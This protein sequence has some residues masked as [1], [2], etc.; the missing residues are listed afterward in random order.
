MSIAIIVAVAENGVIG[1]DNQLIWRLSSDLKRFK[2]LTMGNP[3]LMGRK[4]H[5]SIGK[6]L[7]GRENIILTRN[8]NYQAENCTIIHDLEA[9][10]NSRKESEE[11]IFIIGGE[12]I[13]RQSL[14]FADEVQLTRVHTSIEGDAFFPELDSS[15]KEMENVP[16][17]K[18][19]KNEYDYSFC[20]YKKA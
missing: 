16:H 9:F 13:Y 1:K 11:T 17:Q 15:W 12:E 3:I 5:E 4:T 2:A 14:Q 10:I 8:T 7:P 6:A 18:D 20:I 19:E